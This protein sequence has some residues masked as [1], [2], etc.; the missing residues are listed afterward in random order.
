MLFIYF[1]KDDLSENLQSWNDSFWD[2]A[3]IPQLDGTCDDDRK[4]TIKDIYFNT[5]CH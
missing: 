4:Y 2:G 3:N 1:S 5:F